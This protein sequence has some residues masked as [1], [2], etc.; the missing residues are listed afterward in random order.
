MT[1]LRCTRCHR[2]PAAGADF[3]RPDECH[4]CREARLTENLQRV[5][6]GSGHGPP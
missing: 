6:E 3:W 5:D 1:R 4:D 2:R